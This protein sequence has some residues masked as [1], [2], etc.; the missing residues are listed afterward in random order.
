MKKISFEKERCMTCHNCELGCATVHSSGKNLISAIEENVM[1]RIHIIF[2][3][4]KNVVAAEQCKHCKK[5]KCIEACPEGALYQDKR[6]M[7][8]LDW[9]KCTGCGACEEACPFHAIRVTAKCI[10]CDLCKDVSDVPACVMY[11]PT[12]ALTYKEA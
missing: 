5:A 2:N 10:K 8:L 1:P 7:V 6:G 12:G 3:E 11:C 4:K 9:D